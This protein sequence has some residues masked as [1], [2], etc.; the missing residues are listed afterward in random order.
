MAAIHYIDAAKG[1]VFNV[2]GG[3]ENS[4]LLLEL[5]VLLEQIANVNNFNKIPVRASD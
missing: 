5:L 3:I 2:G 1:Y 4:Q